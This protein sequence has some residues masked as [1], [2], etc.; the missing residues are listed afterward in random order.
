MSNQLTQKLEDTYEPMMAI[1]VYASQGS[2][3]YLEQRNITDGKMGAGRP[4]T[5]KCVT[6]IFRAI[7]EDSEDLSE[8]YHGVIPRNLLYADTTTGRTRL[9]WYNP[10]M[11][12]K[13]YF[14]GSLGIPEG[15]I[16]MPGVLYEANDNTLNVYCFNGK[17]PKDTLWQAQFFNVNNHAVCLGTAKAKRPKSLTYIEAME[18][19]ETMFWNSEFS[20]LYGG[21]P[22]NGNLALITKSCIQNG[23]PFPTSVLIKSKTKLKD[24][25]R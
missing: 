23:D 22:I 1:I 5:K 15:E 10:P 20:H 7:V 12:R 2:A 14:V 16:V 4:L 3:P 13:M 21:N 24:L 19:W 25:L 9:I 6:D 8:G 17:V 11:K 18:Y